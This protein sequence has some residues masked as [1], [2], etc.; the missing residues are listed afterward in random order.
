MEL[1]AHMVQTTVHSADDRQG[2]DINA[3]DELGYS[4]SDTS[5]GIPINNADNTLSF[6]YLLTPTSSELMCTQRELSCDFYDIYAVH[7]SFRLKR[8][9]H[10]DYARQ[11]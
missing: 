6:T 9:T 11:I 5:I 10:G 2:A 7:G 4:S 8:S 1:R 3:T